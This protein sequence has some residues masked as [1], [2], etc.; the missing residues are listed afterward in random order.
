MAG[1][2]GSELNINS[3]VKNLTSILKF[4]ESGCHCE[5]ESEKIKNWVALGSYMNPRKQKSAADFTSDFRRGCR[6]APLGVILYLS[7]RAPKG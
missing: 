2:H 6:Y 3:T 7:F 5:D 4:Y 1:L